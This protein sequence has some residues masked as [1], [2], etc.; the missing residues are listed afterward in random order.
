MLLEDIGIRVVLET[1]HAGW[2]D[3]TA[4]GPGFGAMPVWQWKKTYNWIVPAQSQG[5]S[6]AWP[7]LS[8]TR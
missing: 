1:H 2:A 6:A 8:A 4:G 7:P 5:A 3:V